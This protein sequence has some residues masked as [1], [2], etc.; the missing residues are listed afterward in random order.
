VLRIGHRLLIPVT[1]P[2]GTS[3]HL[4][5][6]AGRVLCEHNPYRRRPGEDEET[7]FGVAT[8]TQGLKCWMSASKPCKRCRRSSSGRGDLDHLET[9]RV[10]P[11][12]QQ[13][14]DVKPVDR[15][16]GDVEGDHG[17]HSNGGMKITSST[18]ATHLNN[19]RRRLRVCCTELIVD[20]WQSLARG[21]E[22]T[23]GEGKTSGELDGG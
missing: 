6:S 7:E 20:S 1:V 17:P 19:C 11:A 14:H 18:D 12:A 13:L 9:A 10:M 8:E 23:R 4:S 16:Q 21:C 15:G 3:R 2:L 22:P 5:G